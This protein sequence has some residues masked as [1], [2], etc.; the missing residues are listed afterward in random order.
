MKNIFILGLL[1]GSM[2]STSALA[3][4]FVSIAAHTNKQRTQIINL[5]VSIE[6]TYSDRVWALVTPKYLN[7]LKKHGFKI[8]SNVSDEIFF[9]AEKRTGQFPK[10]DERFHTYEQIIASLQNLQKANSD[11]SELVT[12]GKSLE[13]RD[14]LAIHINTT[15]TAL[16]RGESNKPGVF[17]MG[18]HHAREHL[19]AEI[20]LMLAEYLLKNKADQKIGKLLASRDIWILPMVNPDGAEYDISTKRYKMWRKNRR[21]NHDGT[22]GVD[23]NRNYDYHFGSEGAS[24]DPDSE[25]YHG[26]SAFSEPETQAIRNFVN[27]HVNLKTLLSFHTYSE[28]ILYPWGWTEKPVEKEADRK[29]FETMAKTMAK[30]NHYKAETSSGL[31]LVS[32]ETTDWAYGTHGIFGFTFELTPRSSSAGGFYPGAKVIDSTFQAN[33]NPCLYLIDLTDNPHRALSQGAGAS[34][35]YK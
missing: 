6:E 31:Y 18:N 26:P 32:G 8:L 11:I 35:W 27:S 3:G 21:K 4:R 19:S 33:L 7:R 23:L 29:T 20:P 24:N 15:K 13:G 28:L 5:G 1:V 25:I 9:E 34:I 10:G 14:M 12:I 2:A 22:M 16:R 17:F 30:W